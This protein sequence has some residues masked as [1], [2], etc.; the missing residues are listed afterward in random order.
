ML[1][2]PFLLI[3]ALLGACIGSFLNVVAWRVP[4]EE[5][6]VRPRSHCPRCGTTLAWFDNM[7]VLSWVL[8]RAR[9]RHCGAGI[10]GRYPA[11]ELLCAGLFVAATATGAS[12]SALPG[13][14]A[15]LVVLAGW[16]LVGLLLPLILIDLDHLWLP[17]PLCRWG[18]VLGLGLT[19]IAGFQQGD[20]AGRT[21]LFWHLLAAS[22]GLLGFE[23]TSAVAQKLL[24]KPALGLG[25]A[26]LAALLGAWLGL[27]GLGLSVLLSVFSGALFGL[28]GLISGRLKRGQ[29]FPFG[30]FL[31]G[32]GLAVWMAGNGFWLQRFS[33]WLGWSAL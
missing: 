7:P 29:P 11:V 8:L 1:P 6:V 31:A 20:A 10:S 25:D 27:T 24:G 12:S 5:S 16:L 23:T 17:E 9:C 30:P 15:A 4:R 33:D 19:A 32:G 26:K 14:P 2:A 18:V 28:L 13:A 3:A 22:A 21:L